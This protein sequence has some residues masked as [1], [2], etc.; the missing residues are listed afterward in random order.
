VFEIDV[1]SV[2]SPFIHQTSVQL[3]QA[4]EQAAAKSPSLVVLNEFDALA[5]K[6]QAGMHEHKIEEVSQMLRLLEDAPE[7]G[8]VVVATTNKRHMMDDAMLRRGRFDHVVEVG[9]PDDTE[10]R[11]AIIGM[12]ADRPHAAGLN[13]DAVVQRLSNRPM[14]D[15]AWAINEAARRAVKA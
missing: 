15:L 12:L 14:S 10:L 7:R 13:L 6:R 5:T 3:R 4:F 2:G 11:A 8:I 9:Y 1:G